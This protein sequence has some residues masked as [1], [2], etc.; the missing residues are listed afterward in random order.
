MKI[1]TYLMV[2]ICCMCFLFDRSTATAPLNI[3]N[4]NIACEA[5]QYVD[6]N[7]YATGDEVK[8]HG[9]LYKCKVGGWCSIGGPYEPGGVSDWAWPSA[10]EELGP[11]GGGG[12]GGGNVAPQITSTIAPV[13]YLES[14]SAVSLTAQV[15]DDGS[16][17]E[18]TFQIL[19][20]TG[21]NHVGLPQGNDVYQATSWIPNNYGD[22]V[23]RITAVDNQGERTTVES[24]LS[25]KRPSGGG[26]GSFLITKTVYNQMFPYRYGTDLSDYTLDPAKDFYTYE[27]LIEAVNRMSNI[28]V[29][30]ERRKGTNLYRLTRRDKQTNVTGVIR[31]DEHFDASWNESKPIVRQTIDYAM[32]V[33]EGNATTRKREL[34]AFLSNIAQET[35]GGWDTAPGGRYSWGL[36]FRE[37]QGYEGTTRIGYRVPHSLYPPAP[38]KSYHGRGPIQLSYNYNYGQVSAFLYGDKNVLLNN[39]ERIIQDAALAF[40]TAIW[41]WMTPQWPKPSAHDVMVGNWVPTNYDLSKNRKPGLGMTVNII[42]GGVE[43]GKGPIDKVRHRIGHYQRF[44]NMLGVSTDLDGTNDCSECDCANMQHFGGNEPE[45]LKSSEL[46]AQYKVGLQP[47]PI[48]ENAT[49]IVELPNESTVTVHCYDVFG[50]VVADLPS[51]KQSSGKHE[52]QLLMHGVSPGLYWIKVIVNGKQHIMKVLKQ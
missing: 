15:T 9:K 2:M 24:N 16:V 50:N 23:V 14:L 42:N 33:S 5:E 30:F 17:T 25:V 48:H 34:A 22:F 38:V 26:G 3:A 32:F 37:E 35:T 8:N 10:W 18:V 7:P 13:V 31:V 36:Y 20:A 12:G 47:N 1:D 27:A 21:S 46:L 28:E 11:C 51:R 40:Q 44:A 19:G 29:V 4:N 41:F 43:C 39:P 52:L 49:I 6:G 45:R